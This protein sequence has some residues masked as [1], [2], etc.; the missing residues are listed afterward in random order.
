MLKLIPIA[1]ALATAIILAG[2]GV[3]DTRDDVIYPY[4]KP[5]PRSASYRNEAPPPPRV[6]STRGGRSSAAGCPS[7]AEELAPGSICPPTAQCF[8]VSG[9]RRCIIYAE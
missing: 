9:G 3:A 6:Q 5:L 2:C 8:E 7:N 4:S 1:A